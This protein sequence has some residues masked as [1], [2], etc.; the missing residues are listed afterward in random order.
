MVCKIILACMLF[1]SSVVYAKTTGAS[2]KGIPTNPMNPQIERQCGMSMRM[3]DLKDVYGEP[4]GFGC[5][6]SYKYGHQAILSMDF[7]FDSNEH[8]GGSRISFVVEMIGINEKINAGKD[9]I[10]RA[11]VEG[12]MPTLSRSAA[13]AESNCGPATD[14]AT[15]QIHGSNWYGWIAEEKFGENHPGCK[16]LKEFTS[17]YRCIHVMV[18]N[19]SMSAQLGGVCLLKNREYSLEN[20]FSY[21]LF[22]NMLDSLRLIE[23]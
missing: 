2:K 14:I 3:P 6:G 18:G 4:L 22:M 7:Q 13:Y 20:G 19:S 5:I 15:T 10:F 8:R 21:D 1:M 11:N 23:N 17:A 16:P 12:G 9:S